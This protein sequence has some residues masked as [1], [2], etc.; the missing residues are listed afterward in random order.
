MLAWRGLR[1]PGRLEAVD[2]LELRTRADELP[3]REVLGRYSIV[4]NADEV[5]ATYRP[6]IE[7][8]GADVVTLQITSLDQPALID[9]LGHE[10]LP[11]LREAGRTRP[12]G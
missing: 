9:M 8:I 7:E 2:P 4:S 6:L 11:R 10:V 1:A 3:R 5:V 12:R